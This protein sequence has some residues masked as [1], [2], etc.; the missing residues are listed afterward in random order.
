M[1]FAGSSVFLACEPFINSKLFEFAF[2]KYGIIYSDTDDLN[3]PEVTF[4]HSD[5]EMTFQHSDC[6]TTFQYFD[7]YVEMETL[8]FRKIIN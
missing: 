1:A 5:K 6:G 3:P 7:M 8:L 2:V 4:Q